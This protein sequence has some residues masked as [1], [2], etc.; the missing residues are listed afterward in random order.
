MALAE[1]DCRKSGN[2]GWERPFFEGDAGAW[3]LLPETLR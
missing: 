1:D 3:A 2:R